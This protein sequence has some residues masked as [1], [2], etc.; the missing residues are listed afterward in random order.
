M[1]RTAG[2]LSAIQLVK[3]AYRGWNANRGAW[4]TALALPAAID[5]VANAA[6]WHHTTSLVDQVQ[7]GTGQEAGLESLLGGEMLLRVLAL[8]A[9]K[10][11]AMTLFAVSWHRLALLGERPRLIPEVRSEH[12]RFALVVFALGLCLSSIMSI[13]FLFTLLPPAGMATILALILALLVYVKLSMLLP[14]A[15]VGVPCRIQDAW[16]MTS[17][18]VLTLFWASL[19]ALLP[20]IFG[21]LLLTLLLPGAQPKLFGEGLLADLVLLAVEALLNYFTLA[22]M[23][24]IISLAYKEIAGLPLAS[25]KNPPNKNRPHGA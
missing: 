14:A 19:L 12:I 5:V 4:L 13:G 7:Q 24:A 10:I 23:V 20:I 15:A 3:E 18:Q 22:M 8:T 11:I 6:F 16:Q 2:S 21:S 9:V 1:N 25:N 17:G